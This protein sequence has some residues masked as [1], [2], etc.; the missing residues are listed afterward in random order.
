MWE[1]KGG[2]RWGLIYAGNAD[3]MKSCQI[4]LAGELAWARAGGSRGADRDRDILDPTQFSPSWDR[5]FP[6]RCAHPLLPS[7][8]ILYD[9]Q[10]HSA[11]S[12]H[13]F[14]S[15]TASNS[16]LAPYS[17]MAYHRGNSL[18][19]TLFSSHLIDPC[20]VQQVSILTAK[21]PFSV[22]L[23]MVTSTF[24]CAYL[25]RYFLTVSPGCFILA[26]TRDPPTLHHGSGPPWG[27]VAP[28][29]EHL[30]ISAQPPQRCRR[31][32]SLSKRPSHR[33]RFANQINDQRVV[34]A[35]WLAPRACQSK[36]DDPL[37]SRPRNLPGG[38]TNLYT[39]YS[40]VFVAII[41]PPA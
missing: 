4:K 20:D 12:L 10:L 23:P 7:V 37:Q 14:S 36:A 15:S 13:C 30:S 39:L 32:S 19:F 31:D 16:I 1:R 3:S 38:G 40:T 9:H 21:M 28:V 41:P 8:A 2:R 5:F 22:D 29:S 6:L 27:R 34:R 25:S 24:V 35:T 11:L 26:A 17:D 18:R 33:F